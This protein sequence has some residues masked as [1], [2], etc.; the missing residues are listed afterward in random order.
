MSGVVYDEGALIAAERSE[1]DFWVDHRVRL[2][3]GMLP[4][5]PAPVIARVSR[6]GR[7]VQL[8]RLLRGCDVIDLTE[9]AAHAAGRLLGTARV[10][11]VVDAVVAAAAAARQADIV[12]GDRHDIQLLL[13]AAESS[14]R[15]IDV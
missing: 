1:R 12:T 15:I 13:D 11:D 9:Q 4:V 5:V 2:E 8:R 14:V 6:S 10:S 7:Q 3:A